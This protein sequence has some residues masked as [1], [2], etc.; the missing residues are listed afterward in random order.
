MTNWIGPTIRKIREEK[1]MSMFELS[2]IAGVSE[3]T[4]QKIETNIVRCRVDILET[5][6][7]A[8]GHEIDVMCIEGKHGSSKTQH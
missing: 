6:L 5:I 1:Q 4:I 3:S 7:N 8:L 2:I